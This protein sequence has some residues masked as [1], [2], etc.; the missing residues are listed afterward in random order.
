[1]S[2]P[3]KVQE[4]LDLSRVCDDGKKVFIVQRDSPEQSFRC[5]DIF[6]A[7]A[8]M[9]LNFDKTI[10]DRDRFSMWKTWIS[11]IVGTKVSVVRASQK[12]SPYPA[13]NLTG[14]IDT[15]YY[16]SLF[17]MSLNMNMY[18]IL[19]EVIIVYSSPESSENSKVFFQAYICTLLRIT[20]HWEDVNQS[21]VQKSEK[22][23]CKKVRKQR[24]LATP[25]ND[26][27]AP[28]ISAVHFE[29]AL[30]SAEFPVQSVFLWTKY[31]F[32]SSKVCTM[33]HTTL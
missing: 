17:W 30:C 5:S 12:R 11:V 3:T 22:A 14:W 7:V 13:P 21:K 25:W 10:L 26:G 20:H 24:W 9:K 29:K 8:W 23:K 33:T 27:T 32:T 31:I 6:I 4:L 28:S 15:A 19:V 2:T 1:M 16:L 18:C